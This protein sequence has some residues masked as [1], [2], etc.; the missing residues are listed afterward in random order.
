MPEKSIQEALKA[1]EP[2]L[3]AIRKKSGIPGSA[4]GVVHKGEVVYKY[5]LGQRDVEQNL[6]VEA[7]TIFSLNSLTKALTVAAFASLVEEGKADWDEAI[8]KT[9][10]DFAEGRDDL[11]QAMTAVDLMSMRSSHSTIYSL[12]C[13]SRFL[14]EKDQTVEFWNRSDRVGNPRSSFIYNNTA[15]G[16]IC[17]LVEKI[18]GQPFHKFLQERFFD[19]LGLKNTRVWDGKRT[20]NQAVPHG[21]LDD[22]RPFKI[23]DLPTYHDGFEEGANGVIS[24]IDDMLKLYSTFLAAF[25]AQLKDNSTSTDGNPFKQCNKIF[26]AHNLLVP[27]Q[28][29]ADL[30][31]NGVQA[32]CCGWTCAQLPCSLSGMLINLSYMGDENMP[33][34]LEDGPSHMVYYHYGLWFGSMSSIYLIP[35]TETI[36]IGLGNA[37]GFCDPLDLSAQIILEAIFDAPKPNDYE[38]IADIIVKRRL[39][40]Y[41]ARRRQLDESKENDAPPSWNLE[42]YVG[43]F[44][45]TH[46]D[47]RIEI[48]KNDNGLTLCFQQIPEE[49]YPLAHYYED[50]FEWLM[51]HNEAARRN[52]PEWFQ[53]G[54][55]YVIHYEGKNRFKWTAGEGETGEYIFERATDSK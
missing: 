21:I 46:F 38:R 31:R 27:E 25:K 28:T 4:I 51:S 30:L 45:C 14:L 53:F 10:P 22:M 8:K 29:S 43:L 19:P 7:D 37:A 48:S 11:E 5:C 15:Y 40:D 24:S 9:L 41:P 1:I 55:F 13:Q 34:I 54:S 39:D 42:E 20:S 2:R 18:S 3:D 35:D 6:P 33:I 47:F 36:I 17:I 44:R 12:A 50:K 32:Y 26:Q 23:D 52:R 16:I 49:T